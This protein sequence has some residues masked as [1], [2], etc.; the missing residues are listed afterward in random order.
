MTALPRVAVCLDI[1]TRAA[2]AR[3]EVLDDQGR[4]DRGDA[5]SKHRET[6]DVL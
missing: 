1:T 5:T 6:Y 3:R 2:L 4:F